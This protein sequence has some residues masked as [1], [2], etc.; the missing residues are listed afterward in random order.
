[1]GAPDSQ[2]GHRNRSAASRKKRRTAAS[3]PGTFLVLVCAP[4]GSLW[5]LLLGADQILQHRLVL[6]KKERVS[7]AE[8]RAGQRPQA[9]DLHGLLRQNDRLRA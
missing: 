6:A 4:G 3:A 5:I 1:M 7:S 8:H 2:S 9:L